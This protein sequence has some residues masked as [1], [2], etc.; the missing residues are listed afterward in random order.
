MHRMYANDVIERIVLQKT[1]SGDDALI[2]AVRSGSA[3][4]CQ[5]LF[6]QC[7]YTFNTTCLGRPEVKKAILMAQESHDRSVLTLF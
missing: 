4:A 5:V 6:D 1:K 2:C 3:R 7:G